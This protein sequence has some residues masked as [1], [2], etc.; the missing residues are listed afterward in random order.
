M[1]EQ[2]SNPIALCSLAVASCLALLAGC[3]SSSAFTTTTATSGAPVGKCD[4]LA[5]PGHW[6]EISPPGMNK[7]PPYTGALVTLVH[8]NNAGTL[9]VTTS[10]SGLYKSTDCGASWTKTNT[11]R[12]GTMIDQ[13]AVWSAVIDPVNPDTIYALTGYGP[14]GLWKSTNG[15]VDWHNV[16]PA[17]MGM[18][19]F[20][21]RIGMDP[22]N[23]LHLLLNFHENCTGGHT[24]VCFG[25]S[26]D[27]GATWAVLDFPPALQGSWGEGWFPSPIDATHWLLE[28]WGLY[29]TAD[30]GKTWTV[31]DTGGAAGIGGPFYKAA[32]GS[33]W[34]SSLQGV[35]TSTDGAH[36]TR[37]P[38][39]GSQMDGITGC[40]NSLYS[41]VGFQVPQDNTYVYTATLAN[42][43]AWSVLQTP[44][45]PQPMVSGANSITCDASHGIVY[46]AAQGA[47][48][49]RMA[50]GV[51]N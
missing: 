19:G 43:T 46:V 24:R 45:L 33:L 39:S 18:P 3:G 4:G 20:V 35:L 16:L 26:K 14:S 27:G 47:G 32:D 28:A 6:Q 10:Y 51:G 34:L 22:T 13:G 30:A 23:H 31:L 40:G 1:S 25:E 42:T 50:T 11:G 49:W 2:H 5:A 38:K 7:A 48:L 44:G 21:A 36:W 17:N 9:Y 29:Y 8:P 37:I 15:G 41:V 12:N